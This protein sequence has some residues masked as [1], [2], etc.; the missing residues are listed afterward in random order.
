[1]FNRR[2]IACFLLCCVIVIVFVSASWQPKPKVS[3]ISSPPTI[4]E[5]VRQRQIH[6]ATKR[7]AAYRATSTTI[8]VSK[9]KPARSAPRSSN[10]GLADYHY[11][12]DCIVAGESGGDYTA[13]NDESTASGIAQWIKGTWNNW[14]GYSEAYL[15]PPDVQEARLYYDLSQSLKSIQG[16]WAAQRGRCNF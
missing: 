9:A 16:K 1:M 13:E 6:A 4:A 3:K 5:Q 8:R 15:A 14:G 12:R 7:I 2:T 11:L 10:T